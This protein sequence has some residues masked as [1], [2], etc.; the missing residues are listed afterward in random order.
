VRGEFLLPVELLLGWDD[1]LDSTN[2]GKVRRAGRRYSYEFPDFPFAFPAILHQWI[3]YRAL[4]GLCRS[5]VGLGIIP[6]YPDY[7]TIWRRVGRTVPEMVL[8]S[9]EEWEAAVAASPRPASG[10]GARAS[11]GTR[12]TAGRGGSS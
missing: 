12:C 8:P 5:L 2:Q 3:D 4:E 6:A 9:A 11:R 10:L 1:E 7:A